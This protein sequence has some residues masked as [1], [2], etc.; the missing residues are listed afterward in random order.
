[1]SFILGGKMPLKMSHAY[2]FVSDIYPF[3]VA[4]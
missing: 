2:S 4:M 3:N 1:M